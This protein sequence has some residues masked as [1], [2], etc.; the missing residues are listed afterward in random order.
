YPFVTSSNPVA[1][2]A[3]IGSGVGPR[4]IDEVWGIT[5]AYATRV[6][7]GPFPTELTDELGDQLR[8]R[9]GEYGTTTG[10][11]RRVGWI[12]VVALRYAA[13]INSLSA[14]C[15]TK[16]DVLSGL[17]RILVCTSYSSAEGATLEDFPFHQTVLH[18]AE[19]RYEELPGWDEEL[20][21]VRTEDDLPQAA[22]DYLEYIAEA[23]GVPVVL[24]GVGPAREQTIWTGAAQATAPLRA[25][26]SS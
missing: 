5:K 22:R 11:S 17:D 10:R 13:R 19:A 14:L 25:M 9:G 15:V 26:A 3:C 18:H 12:D 16:L 24:V 21:D 4:D 8:E 6:G 1:A 20:G 2:S 23:V 7:A